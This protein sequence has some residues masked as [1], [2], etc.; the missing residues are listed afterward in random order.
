MTRSTTLPCHIDTRQD[1]NLSILSILLL[2]LVFPQVKHY[3]DTA[4]LL[5]RPTYTRLPNFIV[6]DSLH[7]GPPLFQRMKELTAAGTVQVLH[8]IPF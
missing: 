1:L 7:I 3:V 4:G 2:L 5:T 8:L 6:S